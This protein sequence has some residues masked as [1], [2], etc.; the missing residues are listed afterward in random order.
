M[1]VRV[2]TVLVSVVVNPSPFSHLV[3]H[4]I[5]AATSSKELLSAKILDGHRID[6]ECSGW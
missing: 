5:I 6:R 4:E 2:S 1:E 3:D